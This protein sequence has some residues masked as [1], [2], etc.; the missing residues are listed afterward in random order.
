VAGGS[1]LS[2][3]GNLVALTG[4]STLNILNGGLVGLDG[5]SVFKLTGSFGAFGTG[6][7][8][9]N[10]PTALGGFT[11]DTSIV[12]GFGVALKTGVASAGQVTVAGTFTPFTGAGAVTGNGIVLKLD[13]AGSKVKL[14]TTG[15]P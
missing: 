11:V 4:G 5:T 8:T 9:I 3:T 7:N 2:V 15:C 13:D 14:C 12:P 6:T 1:F 10:L